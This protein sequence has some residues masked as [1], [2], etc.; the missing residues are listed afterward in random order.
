LPLDAERRQL[1][2]PQQVLAR[3]A[4]GIDEA[5]ARKATP[6]LRAALDELIG[7]ARAHLNTAFELLPKRPANVRPLFLP[8][9]LVRYDL[10]QMSLKDADPFAPRARSRLRTLWTLWRASRSREFQ[11]A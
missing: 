11:G 8:L 9:A 6:Q 10:E 4:S 3:H 2:V 1:F 5:F 7:E